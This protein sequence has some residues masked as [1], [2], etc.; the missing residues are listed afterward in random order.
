ML[1]QYAEALCAKRLVLASASPRRR[2]ILGN[3]VRFSQREEVADCCFSPQPLS[4]AD[5]PHPEAQGLKFEVVV[6][7][8][9]EDLDKVE[10]S[11]AADY[12]KATAMHKAVEVADRMERC[13]DEKTPFMIIGSDTVVEAPDGSIMEKP[14]DEKEAMAMLLSLQGVT[15]QVHSGVGIVFP[16]PSRP[17]GRLVKSFSETTCV[18]FAE[19]RK[20]EMAAYI[21]TGEPFDKAGGYGTSLSSNSKH[22]FCLFINTSCVYR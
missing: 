8:F 2:E 16:D 22:C 21:K 5:S 9:H 11:S 4:T 6:S 15:H 17:G 20:A 7:K 1:L 14:S 19:L 10:F 18:T 3:L 13:K 12:A